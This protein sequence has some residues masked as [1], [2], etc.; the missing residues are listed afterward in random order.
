[1]FRAP[2]LTPLIKILLGGMLGVFIVQALLL[3]VTGLDI[4]PL[5]AIQGAGIGSVWQVATHVLAMPVTSDSLMSL[6]ISLLFLWLMGA[7]FEER[8]G[9]AE[10]IKLLAVGTL[11]AGVVGVVASEL[12]GGA[13]FG[14]GPWLGV[15]IT[16]FAATI[17]QGAQLSFFGVIPMKRNTLIY[18]MVAFIVISALA[19]G[20]WAA[21]FASLASLAG[22]WLYMRWR[23]TPRAR[24]PE[25]R[26]KNGGRGR[27]GFR[28][29]EGGLGKH[30]DDDDD[31]PH[32]PDKR[33]KYL[34]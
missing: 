6:M 10:T 3:R 31:D 7:P 27:G 5:L 34:N 33:P 21:M 13:V 23:L 14:P 15:L 19:S 25:P 22:G 8:F 11:S 2:P 18:I 30:D 12:L 16:G 32:D 26:R 29:I 20:N 1:V 28:V 24:K 9:K 4:V 17:P